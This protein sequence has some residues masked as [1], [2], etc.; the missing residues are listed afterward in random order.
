MHM[1]NMS[2]VQARTPESLKAD[3]V[4]ILE[5]LGLNLSTYINMSLKQLVIQKG[6][7]FEVKL[8]PSTYTVNETVREVGATLRMEGMKLEK[9][10]L[11]LLN[12]YRKGELSGDD[13]RT[14]ILSEV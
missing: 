2:M 12:A 4:D 14:Q 13:I 6:I 7:P 5:K 3:A 8:N 10:E 9:D 11:E 1:E